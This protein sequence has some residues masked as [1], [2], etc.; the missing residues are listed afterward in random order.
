MNNKEKIIE[1]KELKCPLCN[2]NRF[3]ENNF[4]IEAL[5]VMRNNIPKYVDN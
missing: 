1:H 4:K 2:G 3:T 5:Y